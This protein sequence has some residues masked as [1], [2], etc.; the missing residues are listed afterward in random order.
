MVR[1]FAPG[2]FHPCTYLQQWLV[3]RVRITYNRQ[4]VMVVK[5]A[6][7]PVFMQAQ[8]DHPTKGARIAHQDVRVVLPIDCGAVGYYVCAG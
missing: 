4:R 2:V 3:I 7:H 5:K 8:I 1:S 6:I